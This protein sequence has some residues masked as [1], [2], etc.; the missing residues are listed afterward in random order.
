MIL[1][2]IQ[3]LYSLKSLDSGLMTAGMTSFARASS[4]TAFNHYCLFVFIRGQQRFLGLMVLQEA[5][6]GGSSLG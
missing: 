6:M 4:V 2:G 5:H 1:A 3:H